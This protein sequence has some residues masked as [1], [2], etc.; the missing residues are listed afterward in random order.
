M[1]M[2]FENTDMSLL[3]PLVVDTAAPIQA[4]AM[5][6]LPGVIR[7]IAPTTELLGRNAC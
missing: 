7:E 2:T 3:P 6:D 1:M 5:S 4:V